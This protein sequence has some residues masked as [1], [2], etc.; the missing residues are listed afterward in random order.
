MSSEADVLDARNATCCE[1]SE[2]A[3][4]QAALTCGQWEL[5]SRLGRLLSLPGCPLLLAPLSALELA[6]WTRPSMGL[7]PPG[8]PRVRPVAGPGGSLHLSSHGPDVKGA[9]G[10]DVMPPSLT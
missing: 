4:F 5:R 9:K 7:M 6:Q 2:S 10:L 3:G 1:G 8:T